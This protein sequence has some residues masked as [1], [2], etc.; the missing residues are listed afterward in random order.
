SDAEKPLRTNHTE[1]L[2]TLPVCN[3]DFS[4][5]DNEGSAILNNNQSR[6]TVHVLETNSPCNVSAGKISRIDDKPKLPEMPELFDHMPWSSTLLA[7]SDVRP[8]AQKQPDI[9][10][11]P[12]LRD[13]ICQCKEYSQ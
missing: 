7:D 13:N 2:S 8:L 5:T 6:R 4:Q 11:K 3:S 9:L 12:S 10:N 1:S